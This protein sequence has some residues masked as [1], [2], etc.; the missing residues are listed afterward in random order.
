MQSQVALSALNEIVKK[1]VFIA[2]VM[3]LA[4]C[5]LFK[6]KKVQ[7]ADVVA[8]VNDEY[9]YASDLSNITKGLTGADSLT[10]L[11]SY[12]ESWTRK[13]LLLQKA[14]ENI[15]EDDLGISKKVEDYRESLLLYEYEKALINQKLDTNFTAQEMSAWYEKM[16][17][18]FTLQTDVYRVQFIRID[19]NTEDIAKAKKWI[20]NPKDEEET[21]KM[22][23]FVKEFSQG[24]SLDDGGMWY[25]KEKVLKNFPVSEGD[26]ASLASSRKFKEFKEGDMLWFVRISEVLRKDEPAPLEFITDKIEKAIMEKRKMAMIDK[27]Y[28]KI[29][30]DGLNNKSLEIYVK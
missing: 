4:S 10:A 2:M 12:A 13:K 16:K 27:I 29:Y 19:K 9:L 25:E 24:Y 22:K 7:D 26:V 23:A 3:L 28:N 15:E 17:G 5:S 21:E 30:Q 1:V 11:K 6:K 20:L 14:S 18:D 8:R